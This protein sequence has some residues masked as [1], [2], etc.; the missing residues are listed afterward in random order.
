[1]YLF[2]TTWTKVQSFMNEYVT[3]DAVKTRA[4][5]TLVPLVERMECVKVPTYPDQFLITQQNH[6]LVVRFIWQPVH[7][8]KFGIRTREDCMSTCT[9]HRYSTVSMHQPCTGT[10]K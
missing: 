2:F 4:F 7:A 9:N 8:L 5:M 3:V 6:T 1:M 10:D